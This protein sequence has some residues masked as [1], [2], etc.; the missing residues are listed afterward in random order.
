MVEDLLRFIAKEKNIDTN[1]CMNTLIQNIKFNFDF[2]FPQEIYNKIDIIRFNGN[3]P[4]VNNNIRNRI[5]KS[6]IQL[7]ELHIIFCV[8][9][10]K[11]LNHNL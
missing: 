10:L 3:E 6:P 8:A 9:I 5:I 7:L 4:V 2:L 1:I 11:K